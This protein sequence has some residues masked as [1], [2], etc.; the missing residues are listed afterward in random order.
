MTGP[1]PPACVAVRAL[2]ARP[3]GYHDRTRP[4]A[5][6]FWYVLRLYLAVR[7]R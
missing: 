4:V 2:T 1:N 7:R 6:T 5:L 3:A